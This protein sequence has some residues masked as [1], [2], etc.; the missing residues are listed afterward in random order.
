M[1]SIMVAG[2]LI[3][4]V[5][6]SPITVLAEENKSGFKVVSQEEKYYKTIS[7]QSNSRI[8]EESINSE[9]VTVEISKK[10]YEEAQP[11]TSTS[12]RSSTTIETTY[13]R[14]TT[15]ILNNGS[16]YRY[17]ATLT[18]KNFPSTRSYD[19][20][21]IGHNNN[22]NHTNISFSQS[23]C[24]A[25]SGCTTSTTRNTNTSSTGVGVTF[26]LPKGNLTSLSQTL[27]YDV[28][29]KTNLTIISQS[30]YGDYSHATKSVSLSQAQQ[31]SVG[32]SG[33]ILNGGISGYFDEISP[34]VA[35]WQGNW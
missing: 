32:T 11:K 33:I 16:K 18:W 5:L 29:K 13:K 1:K 26:T 7:K 25:N 22:L 23:Y 9:T 34:A 35:T 15:S 27:Y 31:Y 2:I 28:T 6:I 14:L 3:L 12:T 4:G 21:A 17:Q 30:A 10:E 8:S 24:M 20:L 19:I